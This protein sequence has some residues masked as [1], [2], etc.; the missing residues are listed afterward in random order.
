MKAPFVVGRII[1][2]A[3]F[4]NSGI[5][6]LRHRKEMKPYVESKGLPA[7]E[8]MVTLSAVPLLVG[9]TSLVLGIKPRL[10]ALAVLGFLAGVS[11]LMHDFWKTENPQE[12]QQS[13]IDFMKNMA[14]GGA[15]LALT[16][17]EQPQMKTTRKMKTPRVSQSNLI[18]AVRSITHEIAA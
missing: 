18:D 7:P 12:R 6:H 8:I 17:V 9:G 15:A 5:N 1:F 10:G 11:P 4:L 2:G 16:S 13:M 3:F 14:L